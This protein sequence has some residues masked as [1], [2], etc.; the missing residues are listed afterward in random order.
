MREGL[1][2][3]RPGVVV[4]PS[5]CLIHRIHGLLSVLIADLLVVDMVLDIWPLWCA[6]SILAVPRRVVTMQ[7]VENPIDLAPSFIIDTL[8]IGS[9]RAVENDGSIGAERADD[10]ACIAQG[11]FNDMGAA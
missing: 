8:H 11:P 1:K 3:H 4:I 7:Q 5:V 2:R 10:G 6:G 9:W